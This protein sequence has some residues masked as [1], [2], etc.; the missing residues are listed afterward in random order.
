M[1]VAGCHGVFVVVIVVVVIIVIVIVAWA[2]SAHPMAVLE[3]IR[4]I[5]SLFSLYDPGFARA[6]C[7]NRTV[8]YGTVRYG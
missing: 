3:S 2:C 6:Q 1:V 7:W 5:P 8:W 4:R